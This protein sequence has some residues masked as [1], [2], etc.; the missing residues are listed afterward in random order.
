MLLWHSRKRMT[1]HGSTLLR[2]TWGSSMRN[3]HHWITELIM[4]CRHDMH[5]TKP[6]PSSNLYSQWNLSCH[7]AIKMHCLSKMHY[8]SPIFFVYDQI[9]GWGYWYTVGWAI[10]WAH[11]WLWLKSEKKTLNATKENRTLIPIHQSPT[12]TTVLLL[13]A[14]SGLNFRHF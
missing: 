12:P 3:M 6:T 4:L 14:I 2:L 13:L 9:L 11:F 10:F 8:L 1:V 5:N 7:K